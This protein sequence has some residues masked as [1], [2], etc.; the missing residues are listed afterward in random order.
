M[1]HQKKINILRASVNDNIVLPEDQRRA[2]EAGLVEGF[3]KILEAEDAEKRAEQ[4]YKYFSAELRPF[5][6]FGIWNEGG[7]DTQK[8]KGH[9]LL[10][11]GI[12]GEHTRILQ[13]ANTV[14]GHH[15]LTA[16]YP[17]CYVMA[18]ATR[19][20]LQTP[21]VIVYQIVGFTGNA[22]KCEAKCLKVHNTQG[23]QSRLPEEIL[24][25]IENMM[26]LCREMACAPNLRGM[27]WKI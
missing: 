12:N 4:P 3:I 18:A 21:A 16:A 11:I 7:F 19:D 17:G 27:D 14:N 15:L 26:Q 1:T 8:N 25:Q 22:E 10:C 13:K 24:P 6:G 9:A 23:M 2:L 20:I 5:E